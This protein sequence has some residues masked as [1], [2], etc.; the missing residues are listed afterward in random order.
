MFCPVILLFGNFSFGNFSPRH[1]FTQVEISS[2]C[3]FSLLSTSRFSFGISFSARPRGSPCSF[4]FSQLCPY[5]VNLFFVVPEM[6]NTR[7]IKFAICVEEGEGE[8]GIEFMLI[9]K[10][11]FL[12]KTPKIHFLTF[13]EEKMVQKS[14]NSSGNGF[15]FYFFSR[16]QPTSFDKPVA[17][18]RT[19]QQQRC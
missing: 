6:A 1:F 19:R 4:K 11:P 8:R 12:V 10:E 3:F 5:K 17:T 14:T 15:L 16:G 2:F 18:Q 9:G 13:L 7:L